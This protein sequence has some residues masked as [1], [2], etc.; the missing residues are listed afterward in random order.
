[1]LFENPIR[2]QQWKEIVDKKDN[3]DLIVIGG[4]ITGAGVFRQASESGLKALLV[5]QKDFAWG[6]SSR[7]SKMVHG[8]FRYIAQGDIKLTKEALHERE[9]M[10][11]EVPGLVD[12]KTFLFPLRRGRFP[13]RFSLSILLKVYDLLAGVN[14]CDFVK[15]DDLDK[16]IP[17]IDQPNMKGA[18]SY[19]DAI[20]DDSRLVSRVIGEGESF[21]GLAIN[22]V[23][24]QKII[25]GAEGE[26]TG[27]EISNGET[28]ETLV[29]EVKAVVNATGAWADDLMMQKGDTKKVRPLRGSHL[30]L[31]AKKFPISTAL[32]LVH[33][34]DGRPV[35]MFPWY[36]RILLGTTDLDYP[37]NLDI[38]AAI[39]KVEVEYLLR[40]VNEFFPN[41]KADRNDIIST[42]SGVRPV[43]SSGKGVA[44]SKEKR[45][46][47]LWQDKGLITVSGGKLTIFRVIAKE[48]MQA[49]TESFGFADNSASETIFTASEQVSCDHL[50]LS[51][52]YQQVLHGRYGEHLPSFI[53]AFEVELYKEIKDYCFSM[54]DCL[55]AMK[56][57]AVLHLDDLL[58]R[59][60]RL[61]L[62]DNDLELLATLKPHF[63]KELS[64]TDDIWESELERYLDIKGR[65]YSC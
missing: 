40:L 37:E 21:G 24:A 58:L 35:F 36:G 31:D 38:E 15:N 34:D 51:D 16:L 56:N 2:K 32:T 22:Y 30:V 44:P 29:L 10:L 61:G 17:G 53:S 50:K 47:S 8:G 27:L 13:G 33:P 55:W 18:V 9:Q 42:F 3:F 28:G 41:A 48:V 60:T 59:R 64:W 57:E 45:G 23:K 1:M 20:T 54:A 4:G 19:S 39:S 63:K 14:D 43:I 65:Y 49:L 52:T 25:R 46:H 7:S 26:L 62:V 12:R 11:K 5:E 6:T